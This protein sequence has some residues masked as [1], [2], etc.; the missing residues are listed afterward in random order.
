[1]VGKYRIHNEFQK[2]ERIS[3]MHNIKMGICA[4]QEHT[5]VTVMEGE[6]QETWVT[7]ESRSG[8]EKKDL[9]CLFKI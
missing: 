8:I 5:K 7:Q 1:M 2:T 3:I 9:A 6:W 4:E